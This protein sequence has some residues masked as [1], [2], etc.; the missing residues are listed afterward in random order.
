MRATWS[1]MISF[2]LVNIPVKVFAAARDEKISF[3]QMHK[4]DSGRVRY[5]KVCKVCG[6]ILETDDIIKGYEYKK[7][8]YVLVTDE[9]LEK[10]NLNTTKTVSIVSFV[11]SDK[12]APLFF[13]SYF[14]ISPDENG[15]RAYVL[16]REAL[17]TTDMVGVGKVT[18]HSR[19]QLAAVR[20]E[21]NALI[22][23]TMHYVDE[24]VKPDD[25]GIPAADVQVSDNE[26]NLSKILIEHMTSEF[27]PSAYRDDYGSAVKELIA[28]KIE[29]K[30]VVAPPELQPTNVIDIVSALKASL[31]ATEGDSKKAKKKTA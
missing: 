13:D 24:L 7:G 3:H 31:A 4:E 26:L 1:G 20:A 11:A 14:Y 17:R 2:G 18:L 28:K 30:E 9:E 8:Q 5:Q 21:N 29:G 6:N 12:I 22:L 23:E 19:E 25:L 10:I 27:D 15:E 16:L